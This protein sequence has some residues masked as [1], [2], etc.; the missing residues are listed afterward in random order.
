MK[1]KIGKAQK[2]IFIRC[3]K[4]LAQEGIKQ[5]SKS[6]SETIT[7]VSK[8]IN[9]TVQNTTLSATST[10]AGSIMDFGDKFKLMGIE[11]FII[12]GYAIERAFVTLGQHCETGFVN[13]GS[14]VFLRQ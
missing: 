13:M 14:K 1:E 2:D 7:N 5:L 4:V 6:L 10:I 8:D 3:S 11:S 12:W 9:S